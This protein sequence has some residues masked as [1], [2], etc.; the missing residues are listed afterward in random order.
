MDPF[1]GEIRAFPYNFAPQG[2]ALCN[3]QIMAISQA[4][5]LFSLLGTFYGGNG[6]S[7]FP[8]PN[9]QGRIILGIGNGSG[10]YSIGETDGVPSVSLNDTTMPGHTHTIAAGSG[11]NAKQTAPSPATFLG[12]TSS[13]AGG[14]NVYAPPA[15]QTANSTNMRPSGPAGGGQ[16]HNNLAPFLGLNYCIALQGIFPSRA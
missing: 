14:I 11:T 9:L 12:A 6:T 15:L 5:A 4:T 10:T 7:N 3:G 2:W 13:R 1:L 16:S 8:L